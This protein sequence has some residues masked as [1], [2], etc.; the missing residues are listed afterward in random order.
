M[1]QLWPQPLL[2]IMANGRNHSA[3]KKDGEGDLP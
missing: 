1:A 3:R 2:E